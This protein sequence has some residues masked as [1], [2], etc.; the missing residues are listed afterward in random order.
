[1]FICRKKEMEQRYGAIL[2]I[3]NSYEN[4]IFI[5]IWLSLKKKCIL[6]METISD[7]CLYIVLQCYNV[8]QFLTYFLQGLKTEYILGV[9]HREYWMIHWP[10]LLAIVWIGFSPFPLFPVSQLSLFLDLPVCSQSNL[11]TGGGGRG[12]K[13]YDREKAWSSTN[14][15]ILS[16]VCIRLSTV[17][18]IPVSLLFPGQ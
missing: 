17:H 5:I 9:C 7:K 11:L 12:A 4:L 2:T 13:S 1:M 16:S 18:W 15:S 10:G 8:K 14:H 3:P 6:S